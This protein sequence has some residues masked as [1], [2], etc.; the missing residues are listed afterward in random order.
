VA[1]VMD[2]VRKKHVVDAA[3]RWRAEPGYGGFR[4]S[5]RYDILIKGRPY[6]PKAIAAIACELAGV[7]RPRPSEFKG[8]WDGHWHRA[9]K[10]LGYPIVPK[11]DP[12]AADG[13]APT[14]A[15]AQLAADIRAIERDHPVASTTREALVQARLGQGRFRRELLDRWKQGCAV[16]GCTVQQVLRAS[17]IKPWRRCNDKE[18]LN[19]DNGLPLVATLDALFD[20]GLITFNDAGNMI[21]SSQLDEEQQGELLTG[22]P[23]KLLLPPSNALAAFLAMHRRHVFRKV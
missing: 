13:E 19:P 4:D 10:D 11:V 9:L 18:R 22:V 8:A 23:R 5:T 12:E 1:I 6:P 21:V 7:T 17:H 16:T 15:D 2:G 3:A 14:T 20:S